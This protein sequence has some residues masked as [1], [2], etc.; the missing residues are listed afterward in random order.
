MG[1]APSPILFGPGGI[2]SNLQTGLQFNNG[3]GPSILTGTV[4][5]S[6]VATA[7]VEGSLYLNQSSGITY[8]KQDNGS[9]TNWKAF[10]TSLASYL[11]TVQTFTSGSGTYTTPAN[12]SYI[13][14]RM[15]GGGGGGGG[16]NTNATPY[17]IGAA[18]TASSFGG[19]L[20]S[21]GG[22][23]PGAIPTI[24]GG[25]GGTNSVTPT[26]GMT[27]LINQPGNPAQYL[28]DSTT[29]A[30]SGGS[31][32]GSSVFGGAGQGSVSGGGGS[33]NTNSGSGGGG[34]SN[35]GGASCYAA[36]GGGAGGYLEAIITNPTS[37]YAY[38][39]GAGGTGG[40]GNASGPGGNGASGYIEVTEF[41]SSPGA[42]TPVITRL[43]Q[44]VSTNTNAGATASTDYV[45]LVSGTTTIT[46]PS[47][48][49]NTNLYTIKN[50][51]SSLT[52]TINTTSSQ[53]IDGSST[54]TLSVA[55][56]SVDIVSDGSNWRLV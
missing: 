54:V 24:G 9:S 30:Y 40:S 25:T 2:A 43:I 8:Q 38:V 53:T 14:V 44:S 48:V 45:Y 20:L 33:A 3:S 28:N 22:G 13:V 21:A 55:N 42:G 39:V 26:T 47:A 1:V 49:G 34:S 51:D 17:G 18:G 27:V 29:P 50:V 12:C 5:P 16:G 15:V 36:I 11:P 41:Y 31:N 37:S 19:T 32:G 46:L 56:K 6:S 10:F 7:G 52:T 23:A 35:A 4:N